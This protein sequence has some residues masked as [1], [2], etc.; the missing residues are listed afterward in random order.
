MW[1]NYIYCTFI[2]IKKN[3]L[4]LILGIQIISKQRLNTLINTKQARGLGGKS[5]GGGDGWRSGETGAC[6][7]K[8]GGRC[9]RR[10]SSTVS[11]EMYWLL[12]LKLAQPCT[13]SRAWPASPCRR[14]QPS[15]LLDSPSHLKPFLP[16]TSVPFISLLSQ[17][18]FSP[19]PFPS[20]LCTSLTLIYASASPH[21]LLSLLVPCLF[22]PS[23]IRPSSSPSISPQHPSSPCGTRN[24]ISF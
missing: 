5:K 11:T 1:Y 20:L 21:C 7:G 23:L 6:G 4:T 19:L 10:T 18:Q 8:A 13:S 22:L 3:I 16:T 12:C 17:T 14:L 24:S 15:S 9:G 2:K